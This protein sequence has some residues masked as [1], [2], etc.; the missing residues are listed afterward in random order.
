MMPS[1]KPGKF[2]TSVVYTRRAASCARALEGGIQKG[3]P[4]RSRWALRCTTPQS[5]RSSLTE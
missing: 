3:P 4:T 2:P 1:R 5:S